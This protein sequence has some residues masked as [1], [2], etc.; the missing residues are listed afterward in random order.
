MMHNE[1]LWLIAHA[2]VSLAVIISVLRQRS[3]PMAMLAW[4]LAAVALPVLGP[5][6]YIAMGSNRVLNRATRKR[7]RVNRKL[8]QRGMDVEPGVP[9]ADY[10]VAAALPEDL[11]R[12]ERLGE[13]LSRIPATAGNSVR[14]YH[15]SNETYAVLAQA[16]RSAR[17]HIHLEY[18]IWQP[19][20][21][22][23]QFRDLLIDK[24]RAG[25]ECRVLLD[26][27]G[28]LKLT[29]GFTDPMTEAGV[30]LAF[31]LPLFPLRRRRWSPHLRNHRKIAVIDGDL[32]FMG[33]QNIGDEY[34]GRLQRLSPWLDSHMR[35]QGPAALYLQQVF[36]EDWLF[37]ARESLR[38]DDYFSTPRIA[39]DSVVQP[40]PSGPDSDIASL[41]QIIFAAVTQAQA[42]I[43]IATPY[44]V[45]SEPLR[46]ALLHARFRGV[47]V[48]IVVPSRSDNRLVLWAGRSFYDE[49]LDEGVEI[50]EFGEGML[51]SKFIIIDN[52]WLLLGSANMDIRSFRLNFEITAVVYDERQAREL[53]NVISGYCDRSKRI[54]QREIWGRGL[55]L[56]VLEGAARLFSPLL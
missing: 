55:H 24:A 18:Y 51:H 48:R 6:L 28:C 17:R 47:R 54:S 46:M 12:I 56:Q 37:A 36:A 26:A 42:S 3:D 31:F 35:V 14:V 8:R 2:L 50:Y 23:R 13:R 49:L 32:A 34:R 53:S 11:A 40:L 44:F 25:V 10:A 38:G 39:G 16:I 45:P 9:S 5:V 43:D 20:E 1:T 27:V 22:G 4:I 15:D 41:S 52:R 7:T 30:K 29:R 33:S 19:D 21:T